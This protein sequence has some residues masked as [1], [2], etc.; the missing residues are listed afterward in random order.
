MDHKPYEDQL[1][2]L[3]LVSLER[4]LS[5]DLITL[6]D[7]LKAGCGEVGVGLFSHMIVIG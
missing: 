1:R 2:E 3:G 6:H 4:R 7:S 5:G